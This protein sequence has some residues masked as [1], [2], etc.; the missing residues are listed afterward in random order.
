M[1]WPP[2]RVPVWGTSRQ[3][4]TPDPPRAGSGRL[5]DRIGN[6]NPQTHLAVMGTMSPAHPPP[7]TLR[8]DGQ[9]GTRQDVS[10]KGGAR[11]LQESPTLLLLHHPALG[12]LVGCLPACL[13]T[14]AKCWDIN[15]SSLST[16]QQRVSCSPALP[17]SAPTAPTM[18]LRLLLPLLLLAA[19]F[20]I[21]QA[22][23]E[24]HEA[25]LPTSGWDGAGDGCLVGSVEGAGWWCCCGAQ[26]VFLCIWVCMW[27]GAWGLWCSP[28]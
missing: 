21:A 9:L 7:G 19:T 5:Q 6:R 13:K 17:S 20:L 14:K 10:V 11:S 18:A 4:A 15:R 23:G 26:R 1:S 24:G 8:C 28:M 16:R 22:Q 27:L 2:A 12:R 25:P 3:A